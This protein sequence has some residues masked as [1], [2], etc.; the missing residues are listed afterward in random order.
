[1]MTMDMATASV[2]MSI[3]AMYFRHKED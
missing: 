3:V 2:A 1:M